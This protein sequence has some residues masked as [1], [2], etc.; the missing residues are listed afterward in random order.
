MRRLSWGYSRAKSPV[1]KN[2]AG[3]PVLARVSRILAVPSL[4]APPSKVSAMT[5]DEVGILLTSCPLKP[6]GIAQVAGC[7][8]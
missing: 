7:G 3:V 6:V 1:R 4:L 2:V 5:F 8:S